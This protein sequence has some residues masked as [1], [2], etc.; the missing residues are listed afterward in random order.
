MYEQY[1]GLSGRPF[2]LTPDHKFFFE[3]SVH[4]KA[5]SYLLYGLSQGEGFIVITGEVGAGKTTLLR[6]LLSTLDESQYIAAQIV[7]SQLGAKDM[8]RMVATA[9]NIPLRHDDKSVILASIEQFL[10]ENH[11]AKRRVLLLI[12]EAQNL[13]VPALEELRMLSNYQVDN[14]S[15]LQSFLI[16]Q[17]Q[18]RRLLASPG[19]EQLRQRVIASF[20]LG[21]MNEAETADYIRH[22]LRMVNWKGDPEFDESCMAAIYQQTNGIPRRINTLAARLLLFGFLEEIHSFTGEMVDRV[23]D[24]LSQE[25]RQGIPDEPPESDVPVPPK[26]AHAAASGE[27]AEMQRRLHALEVSCERLERAMKHILQLVADTLP[28]G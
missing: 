8:L 2:Q 4:K 14:E 20:H 15:S 24:E 6:H 10:R 17:P 23:A 25:T 11:K 26:A 16:G 28:S 9:F 22:R 1:Y 18:F 5:A 3:S 7:T 12:D 13:S 27:L 19:L 21:P